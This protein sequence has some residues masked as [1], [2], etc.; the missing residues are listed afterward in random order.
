MRANFTQD[1][2]TGKAKISVVTCSE[3]INYMGEIFGFIKDNGFKAKMTTD[4]YKVNFTIIDYDGDHLRSRI[5][6]IMQFISDVQS[7]S[8]EKE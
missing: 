2:M 5:P 8:Y 3:S 1:L 4:F 7:G 6:K